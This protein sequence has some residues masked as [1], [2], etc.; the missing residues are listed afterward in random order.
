MSDKHRCTTCSGNDFR[1]SIL[2]DSEIDLGVTIERECCACGE[3]SFQPYR[4]SGKLFGDNIKWHVVK[5]G[6]NE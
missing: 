6:N 2:E 5:E 1:Y 4:A 3:L